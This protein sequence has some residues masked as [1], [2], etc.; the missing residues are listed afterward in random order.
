MVTANGWYITKHSIG[1]YAGQATEKPWTLRD[2]S[3]LQKSIDAEALAEPVEKAQGML[4]VEAYV[5][6]HGREGRPEKGTVLGRL[7]NGDRVL[8][9]IDASVDALLQMEE[10]E[11]VGAAGKV[12]FNPES[13]CNLVVFDDFAIS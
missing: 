5:I 11:L 12:L 13:G 1:I 6:R 10:T 2:D 3:S 8:A 9:H 7:D 4:T